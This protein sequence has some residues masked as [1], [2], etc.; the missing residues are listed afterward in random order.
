MELFTVVT[1]FIAVIVVLQ[2]VI[3]EK[4]S[5]VTTFDGLSVTG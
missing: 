2:Q 3:L 4:K 5:L 1:T